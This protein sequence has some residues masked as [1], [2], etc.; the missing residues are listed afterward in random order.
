M[1]RFNTLTASLLTLLAVLLL[2]GCG[3]EETDAPEQNSAAADP[4]Y[5]VE[6]EGLTLYAADMPVGSYRLAPLSNSEFNALG[7]AQKTVVA[8]KLLTT[9]YYGMPRDELEQL[10]DAGTFITTIQTNIT[11][12]KND[13]AQVE[14]RLNDN[15]DDEEEFYF[16]TWPKGTSE[17]SRILARFYVFEHL[18]SHYIDFWS[19][20]VL[21]QNIM[22]SPAYELA[23]SHAPNIER[24]YSALV[25][26]AQDET[27]AHYGTFMH[28]ISDDNW[29]RF[30]SPED[31]G[32]EM[33]EIYLK[34]F[35]DTLVPLAGKAL[36]N[37]RLDRDHDTL[38][39]GLDANTEPLQLFGTTVTDGYD[40]Y[41]ELAKSSDFISGVSSRLV[42][43]YFPTFSPTEKSTLVDA[44]V[45]SNPKTWRD[46]LLQIVFSKT[47]LLNSDKPKSAEELFY[48][49]SKKI[50]F[51][52]KRGFFSD[53]A[54]KLQDMNQ[55]SMKYKLGRFREVPLDTQ[56]F[57]TYHKYM[58]E[59]I[60]IRNKNT[61]RSGW[62]EEQFI[63]DELFEGI[64]AGEEQQILDALIDHLFLSTIARTATVEEKT[65]FRNH[66][67]EEDGTYDRSFELFKTSD[68]PLDER[69]RA[70]IVIMDYISRLSQTY[71]FE[72]VQ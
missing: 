43:V 31:N 30:R 7:T 53:F 65:L 57:I 33:L 50:H 55:A 11:K 23:S 67:L 69:V 15:G 32:R 46:I 29:R 4:K 35:D 45:S 38:V 27:T 37:W 36:K 3:G 54:R 20:Y 19:A 1:I 17:V 5:S 44:I 14:A 41:R 39:V 22:F 52:H 59:N 21:T 72:K 10:I 70:S 9:L 61:W 12:K 24:V 60:F 40:F 64:S 71:R 16:S 58:R 42:D 28:M 26:N 6:Y 63:P 66:M 56:S 47:Y 18:D 34:N 8:D 13:L 62:L 2:T 49:L 68:T 51:Q 48:S 25:R